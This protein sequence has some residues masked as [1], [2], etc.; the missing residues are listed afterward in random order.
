MFLFE[1]VS[2][3]RK[4]LVQVGPVCSFHRDAI[5]RLDKQNRKRHNLTSEL[6]P[7]SCWMNPLDIATRDENETDATDLMSQNIE[8]IC[9]RY[10]DSRIATQTD[11]TYTRCSADNPWTFAKSLRADET[12][13]LSIHIV[14]E[15]HVSLRHAKTRTRFREHLLR[16]FH[17]CHTVLGNLILFKCIVCKHRLV[18]FHPEHQPSEPLVMM[19]TYP[20]AIAEWETSPSK[21]RSKQASFHKGKCQRCLE[22][23][24]KV[25]KDTACK[26]SLLSELKI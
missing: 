12:L 19:K 23:L 10:H 6:R 1:G 17:E 18:A 4:D 21:E 22:Q 13:P 2:P 16:Q 25:E 26:G 8:T 9:I 11:V 5:L 20:N 7:N 15:D 14:P 24:A 3:H